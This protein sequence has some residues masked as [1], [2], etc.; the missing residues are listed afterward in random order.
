MCA[1][2]TLGC[3]VCFPT[4]RLVSFVAQY[5]PLRPTGFDAAR[6]HQTYLHWT[7]APLSDAAGCHF[8]SR[9]LACPSRTALAGAESAAP[10]AI[11]C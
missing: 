8:R 10:V 2:M 9:T 3:P 4:G 7:H 5:T 6:A 1:R 11:R